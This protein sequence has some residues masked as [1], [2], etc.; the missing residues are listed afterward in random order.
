MSIKS[1]IL[2]LFFLFCITA[3]EKE[4]CDVP[5]YP[6]QFQINLLEYPYATRFDPGVSMQTVAITLHTESRLRLDFPAETIYINRNAGDYVGYAGMVVWSDMYSQ[7]HA[8]DLCCPHCLDPNFPIEVDGGMAICP[9]CG[10]CFDLM[11][12]YATP[13]K[14]VTSQRLRIFKVSVSGYHISIHN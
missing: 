6:V 8:A 11:S 1:T 12:G 9:L 4:K 3:C 7:I 2:P 10:E 13:T 5:S 14:G